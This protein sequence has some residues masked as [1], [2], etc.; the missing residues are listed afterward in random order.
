MKRY[1]SFSA[2]VVLGLA[3]VVSCASP[4]DNATA[5]IE[6][7]NTIT[8]ADDGQEKTVAKIGIDGMTCE[9]GCAKYI[10][11][12]LGKLEGVLT[13]TV[14]FE[15][16]VASIEFDRSKVTEGALVTTISGLADGAYKVNTVEVEEFV[17]E[18]PEKTKTESSKSE[19]S[20]K[21]EANRENG[22]SHEHV[23]GPMNIEFPNIFDVF[24]SLL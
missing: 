17:K 5:N 9:I 21:E 23:K 1:F 6:V 22:N 10:E 11:G 3:I 20:S 4:A 19:A 14:N 12:K 16:K 15:D 2:L 8:L 13:A 24:R 18:M 7:Q